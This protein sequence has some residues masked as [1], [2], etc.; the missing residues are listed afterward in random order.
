MPEEETGSHLSNNSDYRGSQLP[1]LV[2]FGLTPLQQKIFVSL[3][4]TSGLSTTEISKIN[5]VH[6]SDVY[7]ALRRLVKIGLVEASLDN[8]SRYYAIEPVRAVRLLLDEKRKK[9]FSLES[10]ADAITEWLERS[11]KDQRVLIERD[12]TTATFRLIK[13][14]AVTARVIKAIQTAQSEIIKVVSSQALRRHY[15]EFS[16]YERQATAKNVTVRILTEVK[17]QNFQV[18]QSYSKRVHLRHV[19]SLDRSLRY[20]VIDGVEL[21]LAGT[22]EYKDELDRSILTTGNRVL[23]QGC[24][25][26]FE[27]MWSKSLSIEE[28]LDLIDGSLEQ[29]GRLSKIAD[30]ESSYESR[31]F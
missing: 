29:N 21:V 3:L 7:R 15:F 19:A 6:R 28:R 1:T 31:H 2:E 18:A 26:Y 25:S 8:P 16:E 22:L 11:R 30:D 17:P 14:D 27:D 20:M 13:G 4:G 10:K 23:V 12:N 24:V 9:L 5:A